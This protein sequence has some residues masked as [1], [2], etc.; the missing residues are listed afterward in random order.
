MPALEASLKDSDEAVRTYAASALAIIAPGHPAALALLEGSLPKI[1]KV[2]RSK[3]GGYVPDSVFFAE[4]VGT[5][6]PRAA[7]AIPDL[8]RIYDYSGPLAEPLGAAT[9]ALIKIGPAAVPALVK[10]LEQKPDKTFW[11]GGVIRE[12]GPAAKE[13]VPGLVRLLKK[14]GLSAAGRGGRAPRQSRPGGEG[15]HSGPA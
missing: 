8:I 2:R 4:T 6:G 3:Y 12:L 15:V 9:S 10:A 13:A 11:I 7:P 14:L 5:L 1:G